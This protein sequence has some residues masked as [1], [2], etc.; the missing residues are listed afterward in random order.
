MLKGETLLVL[1]TTH[2]ALEKGFFSGETVPIVLLVY[3]CI[4]PSIVE[5]QRYP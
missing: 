4:N 1:E 5:E 2:G 3:R